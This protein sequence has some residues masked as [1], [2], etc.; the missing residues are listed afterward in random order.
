MVNIGKVATPT[1]DAWR[2]FGMSV[3]VTPKNFIRHCVT[4]V[5][6]ADDPANPTCCGMF[7]SYLGMIVPFH[8]A[9][10]CQHE[11]QHQHSHSD[12]SNHVKCASSI[13]VLAA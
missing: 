3:S 12:N 13:T 5:T 10:Q 8:M 7:V 2:A 4:L 6:M 1:K 9:N 11:Y